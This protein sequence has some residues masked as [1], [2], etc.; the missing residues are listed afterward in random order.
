MLCWEQKENS[1]HVGRNAVGAPETRLQQ[2]I[3]TLLTTP[4]LP[5]NE[6][7]W[8]V[9]VS[10]CKLLFV[11]RINNKV[12]L[13]STGNCIQYPYPMAN[14]NGEEYY[15][16]MCVSVYI[17]TCIYTYICMTEIVRQKLVHFKSTI[18]KKLIKNSK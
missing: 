17:Y 6:G 10:R 1:L 11:K 16:G 5:R 4:T 14:H 3:D 18:N 2:R 9:G 8:G 12:L 15:K 7:A 13:C